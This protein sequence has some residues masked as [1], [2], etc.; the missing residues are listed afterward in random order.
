M[1]QQRT[2]RWHQR[3]PLRQAGMLCK[4]SRLHIQDRQQ[5]TF[6]NGLAARPKE[7]QELRPWHAELECA[8]SLLSPVCQGLGWRRWA[9]AAPVCQAGMPRQQ[10]G[11][12]PPS[13]IRQAASFLPAFR[14]DPLKSQQVMDMGSSA[15]TVDDFG[16]F[17]SLWGGDRV[18]QPRGSSVLPA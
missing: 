17:D 16:R 13:W 5:V 14:S 2:T 8:G 15:A 7:L 6:G 3:L 9:W 11:R 18:R 4:V 1:L 10:P 12:G